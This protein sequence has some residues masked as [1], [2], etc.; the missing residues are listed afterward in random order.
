M[1]PYLFAFDIGVLCSLS[2]GFSNAILEYMASGLPVVA[3]AVGG[4]G[5]QVQ[6]GVT[7][8][9]VPAGDSQALAEPISALVRDPGQRKQFGIIAHKYCRDHYSIEAMISRLQQYYCWLIENGEAN[10]R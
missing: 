4:N 9:L 5:E 1:R 10:A 8:F 7:G 6:D 3:T 2:E